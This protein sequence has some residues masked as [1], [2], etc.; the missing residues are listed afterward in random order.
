[1][2]THRLNF[3]KEFKKGTTL[4]NLTYEGSMDF[5][6]EKD[7]KDWVESINSKKGNRWAFGSAYR[8]IKF[9]ITEIKIPQ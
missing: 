1:M 8:I 4:E 2:Y 6:S 7:A 5:C 9:N 3:T